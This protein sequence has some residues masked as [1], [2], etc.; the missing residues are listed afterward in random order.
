MSGE[1]MLVDGGDGAISRLVQT[2]VKLFA[3]PG[4]G[5]AALVGGLA[6]TVRLA[7]V[8]RATNDVDTVTDDADPSR[9]SLEYLGDHDMAGGGRVEIDGV[10][11]D[12]MP[13]SPLPTHAADL[14]ED[15]IQRLFVLGHRW[16][17]ETAE[18]IAVRVGTPPGRPAGPFALTVATAPA[19]VACKF[20]AIAA[21]RDAGRDKREGDALDLIRLIGDLVRSPAAIAQFSTAPFD[22]AAL[23][24]AQVERWLVT[25]STRAARLFDLGAG[26]RGVTMDPDDISALGSLFEAM[27]DAR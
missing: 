4:F 23:V 26:T 14:P 5:S 11:V 1:V 22:L 16:A 25:G 18:P 17:L 9:L 3:R 21:R 19:L 7:T 20:H 12:V 10:N 27:L 8:H 2:A 15:D 6:V 13:T 24:S